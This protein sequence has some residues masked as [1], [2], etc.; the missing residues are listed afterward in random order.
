MQTDTQDGDDIAQTAATCPF[1]IGVQLVA[2]ID[3][4]LRATV[5]RVE[6]DGV[7]KLLLLGDVAKLRSSFSMLVPVQRTSSTDSKEHCLLDLDVVCAPFG[8]EGPASTASRPSQTPTA[9]GLAA[10]AERRWACS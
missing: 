9:R 1:D 7:L 2:H 3:I 8:F 10:A 4:C 6:V 5:G